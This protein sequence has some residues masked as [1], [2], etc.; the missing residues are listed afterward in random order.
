MKLLID[1]AFE[2][3]SVVTE[4][5]NES[6]GKKEKN[7]YIEGVF[8]TIEKRNR[9]GRVYPRQIWES[10]ISKYQDEIKNN[11][12]KTLGELE[13]PQ[14]VEVDPMR[15]VIKIQKLWIEGDYVKGRAKILNDNSPETNKLKALIDEGMK[16]GVSSR[17]TGRLGKGNIVEDFELQ[18]YD[19]VARPSD[20]NAML[21]GIMESVEKEVKFDEKLNKY[22]C[23]NGECKLVN[24]SVNEGEV[25]DALYTPKNVDAETLLKTLE[26][27]AN[28]PEIEKSI[29]EEKR[30]K[31][32]FQKY[33]GDKIDEA[34]PREIKGDI[35]RV[36]IT[37]KNGKEKRVTDP[38]LLDLYMFSKDE[39]IVKMRTQ[40]RKKTDDG[41]AIDKNKIYEYRRCADIK[42]VW[43]EINVRRAI[44]Q[45][46]QFVMEGGSAIIKTVGKSSICG[47][48]EHPKKG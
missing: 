26:A 9:N 25:D 27:Y 29:E 21:S 16:I 34:A 30:L 36:L 8:S 39:N 44:T 17:G 2:V 41:W 12:Y 47:E 31:E 20:Y 19:V 23:T 3:E 43:I 5:I 18:T 24:E 32:K 28:K 38:S 11:T 15:A 40:Y 37:Y 48:I 4:S 14:R 13:H 35:S 22:I 42:D 1:E 46:V 7:Y 33:F 45:A 10:N 6:T